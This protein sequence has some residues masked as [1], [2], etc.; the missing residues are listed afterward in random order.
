MQNPRQNRYWAVES[1]TNAGAC[2]RTHA[3]CMRSNPSHT[4]T[5]THFTL[6]QPRFRCAIRR[7]CGCRRAKTFLDR[8]WKRKRRYTFS[9]S[10]SLSFSFFLSW[11]HV[12]ELA[13]LTPSLPEG[14]KCICL[15]R[16]QVGMISRDRAQVKLSTFKGTNLH[17]FSSPT[18]LKSEGISSNL[19][20]AHTDNIR[21]R[22]TTWY[23]WNLATAPMCDSSSKAFKLD[24]SRSNPAT[25]VL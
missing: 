25:G 22:S 21:T 13:L 3:R 1:H 11:F 6:L 4:P 24:V 16:Q 7:Q 23:E 18:T 10:F 9:R 8:D 2:A 14:L 5:H 19:L 20:S 17:I 15:S 12:Y